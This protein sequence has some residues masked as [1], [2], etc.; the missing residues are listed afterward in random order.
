MDPERHYHLF[1]KEWCFN[2]LFTVGR[3]GPQTAPKTEKHRIQ[4]GNL[5]ARGQPEIQK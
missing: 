1:A 3:A 4:L 2:K 5:D